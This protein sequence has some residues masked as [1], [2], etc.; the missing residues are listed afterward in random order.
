LPKGA[1]SQS[2]TYSLTFTHCPLTTESS[3]VQGLELLLASASTLQLRYCKPE[4]T[5]RAAVAL[6]PLHLPGTTIKS[7]QPFGLMEANQL[8]QKKDFTAQLSH[9]L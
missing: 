8:K 3:S 9:H 2:P 4:M 1:L 7:H 6:L 5:E